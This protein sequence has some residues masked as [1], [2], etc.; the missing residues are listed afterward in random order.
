M[1]R[2]L[3][4]C[5]ALL[6]IAA[7]VRAE[8]APLPKLTR[9]VN[10]FASVL[11]QASIDTLDQRIRALKAATGDVVIITTVPTVAP[12][13]DV[14]EYAV[15][16]FEHAGIGDSKLDNGLLILIAV[17]EH[18]IRVEVGYG[19]EGIVTD[20][21]AGDTIRT[22]MVPAFRASEYSAGVVAGA[23]KLIDRIAEGR[24]NPASNPAPAAKQKAPLWFS[25]FVIV[26]IVLTGAAL[27]AAIVIAIISSRRKKNGITGDGDNTSSWMALGAMSSLSSSSTDDSRS[28]SSSSSSSSD[29]SSSSS[30]FD[31]YDGGS[32]GGGGAS[33][34]W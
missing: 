16:L 23:S 8:Q 20:G 26:G 33:D 9:T 25:R 31:G 34:S 28:S 3:I 10:D 12:Y 4:A 5:F 29:S 14:N 17:K 2:F 30:S 6:L 32:S 27:I 7:P 11:D 21:F 15:K 18:G 22:L 13:T 19:L 24:A 1:Q